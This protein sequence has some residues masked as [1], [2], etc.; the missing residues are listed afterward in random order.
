MKKRVHN[1][2]SLLK[3]EQIQT[4]GLFVI[5][6]FFF[7]FIAFVYFERIADFSFVDEFNNA[8]VGYF[9]LEGKQVYSQIFLNHHMLMPYLSTVLQYFFEPTTLYKLMLLHRGFVILFS[10]AMGALL[11]YRFRY[12]G[13]GFVLIYE[14]IK[15]Y[16]F[17]NLFLGE[18]LVVYLLVYLFGLN[19]LAL[20]KKQINQF[21]YV[22]AAL[23]TWA[24]V[25]L[26][27]PY[28]PVAMALFLLFLLFAKENKKI[29]VV[30][31][32]L[33]SVLSA[34]TLLTVPLK[35]YFQ[36][37]IVVNA[38][39]V[40]PSETASSHFSISNLFL[41]P[42]QILMHPTSTFLYSVLLLLDLLFLTLLLYL[43]TK[44]AF[45]KVLFIIG[46]LG[47]AAVRTTAPGEQ[48]YGAFHM[49]VWVGLFIIALFFMVKEFWQQNDQPVLRFGVIGFVIY[50]VLYILFSSQAFYW[51]DN[52]KQ[53]TFAIQYNRYEVNG[54]V[55]KRLAGKDDTLFI[56]GW[57]SLIYWKSQVASSYPYTLYYP[58]V[59]R[60]GIEPFK[61]AIEKMYKVNP[62]TFYYQD[63]V[64]G[65]EFAPIP[66]FIKENY[67]MLKYE[68]NTTCIFVNNQEKEKVKKKLE[69]IKEYQYHF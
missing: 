2:L 32:S 52:N 47:L 39:V 5:P 4:V 68:T 40:I 25:F 11:I 24:S 41:Y 26:R 27:E 14:L 48:F 21:D 43:I 7:P 16:L 22:I 35:E 57:D 67:S 58:V 6:A 65:E 3:K 38:Q 36:Q 28:I 45:L 29:K 66:A 13:L 46:V 20:S 56:N 12:V 10:L 61:S 53:E 62:P 33:F 55:I 63:C 51:E 49:I 17:G 19:W 34:I 54:E 9:M 59:S 15:Y 42:L 1:Y 69:T 37:V 50:T 18:S 30:S 23:F 8:V 64:D 31:F 60:F 44:K